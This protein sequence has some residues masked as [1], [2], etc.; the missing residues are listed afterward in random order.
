MEGTLNLVGY[1]LSAIGPA[2]AT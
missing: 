2:I 1:G